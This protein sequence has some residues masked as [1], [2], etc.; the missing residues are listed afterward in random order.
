MK[1]TKA[2]KKAA[3]LAALDEISP[4]C[5]REI[6]KPKKGATILCGHKLNV[7]EPCSLCPCPGFVGE[8]GKDAAE[9]GEALMKQHKELF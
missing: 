3:R 7:H 2:T 6:E 1:K 8:D 9:T 4:A 5:F